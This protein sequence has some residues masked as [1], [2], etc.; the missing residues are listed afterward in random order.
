MRRGRGGGE[1]RAGG[2]RQ[3]RRVP[4]GADRRKAADGGRPPRGARRPGLQRADRRHVTRCIDRLER[5]VPLAPL[6][7]PNNLRPD[8]RDPRAAAA[9]AAGRLLRYGLPPRPSG[10]RRPLR[11]PRSS[12]MRKGCAAT[13][14][15]GSPTS[16]SRDGLPRSRPRSPRA[17]SSSRISAAAPPC[18]RSS[19][20]EASKARWASRRSMA[21]RWARG[22]ASST[23]ALCSTS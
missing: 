15:T 1:R 23:P 3:G 21:C 6:H 13:D 2:A 12:S 11:H 20:G 16:T 9:A 4:A 22:R 7:Q 17:G 18:A 14:S 8:P 10:G 5:F 19:A